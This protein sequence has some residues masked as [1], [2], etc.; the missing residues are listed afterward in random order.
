[1]FALIVI[2]L[3]IQRSMKMPKIVA[4]KRTKKVIQPEP[5]VQEQTQVQE[6]PH[7]EEVPVTIEDVI[8][9]MEKYICLINKPQS[10][11]KLTTKVIGKLP[12][13]KKPPQDWFDKT[14]Y[15][16]TLADMVH[17]CSYYTDG[18]EYYVLRD[19]EVSHYFGNAVIGEEWDTEESKIKAKVESNK[20]LV[21]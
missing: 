3:H 20:V 2:R 8:V 17:W 11:D 19:W 13:G 1:M 10:W 15:I 18:E 9:A 12:L 16:S 21:F 4:R 5:Q 7:P 6:P 14:G